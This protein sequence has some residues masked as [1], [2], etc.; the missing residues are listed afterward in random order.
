MRNGEDERLQLRL[1]FNEPEVDEFV[2]TNSFRLSAEVVADLGPW[3]RELLCY[4][5]F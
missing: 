4:L 3:L 2:S 5:W 1:T